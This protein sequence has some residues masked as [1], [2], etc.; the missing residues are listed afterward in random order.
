[1]RTHFININKKVGLK[2]NKYE[3]MS[4]SITRELLNKN[5]A[6]KYHYYVSDKE[7]SKSE[8]IKDLQYVI[9]ENNRLYYGELKYT[10]EWDY[11]KHYKYGR[12]SAVYNYNDVLEELKNDGV[13]YLFPV[14]SA[15]DLPVFNRRR[16]AR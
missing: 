7:T 14:G 6:F 9:K 16:A 10:F 11:I 12:Y 1:V 13:I 3:Y 15:Y 2:M 8:F 4:F 5:G